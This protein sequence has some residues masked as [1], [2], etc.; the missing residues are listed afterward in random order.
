MIMSGYL[1]LDINDFKNTNT[2]FAGSSMN[3]VS[4]QFVVKNAPAFRNESHITTPSDY[5]SKIDFELASIN[6]P[7][8]ITK[9]FSLDYNNLT[10]TLLSDENFG[11]V[12]K[13]C[14]LYT[15]RCV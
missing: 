11:E 12:Y 14:L 8:V 1:S 4:Y 15:S 2:M 5:L 13:N 3:A 9:N 6:W 7:E 10:Q